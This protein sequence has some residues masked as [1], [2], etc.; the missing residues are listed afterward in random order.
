[1]MT[2]LNEYLGFFDKVN[3]R[4]RNERVAELLPRLDL[5]KRTD[6]EG[7]KKAPPRKIAQ[8]EK[9]LKKLQKP[10]NFKNVEVHFD[11]EHN[12]WEAHFVNAQGA[13]HAINWE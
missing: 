9:E 13:D 12:L 8:L 5:S 2:V 11:E 3:K 4:L 7:D 1:F 6:F 10:E